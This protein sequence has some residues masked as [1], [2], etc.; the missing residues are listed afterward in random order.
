MGHLLS[1]GNFRFLF[2]EDAGTITR[3]VWWLGTLA[4]GL[5][6]GVLTLIWLALS[7]GAHRTLDA[8]NLIDA[9]TAFTYL[10]LIIFAAAVLLIA[11]CHY[12]L[13]AKRFAARGKPGSLAG[14]LPLAALLT[15]AMHWMAP[16]IGD[17]LPAWTSAAVDFVML[18]IVVWNVLELGV[19]PGTGA[20]F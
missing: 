14:L 5:T 3:R 1:A 11:I 12:N 18:V 4:L 20:K 6:L 16:R 15:G 9:R 17:G 13:S 8:T 2:R 7:S 19:K 10:Y